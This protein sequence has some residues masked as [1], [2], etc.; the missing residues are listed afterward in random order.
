MYI[1]T[2]KV[3]KLITETLEDSSVK[4]EKKKK[5]T[6]GKYGKEGQRL[7]GYNGRVYHL[8]GRHQIDCNRAL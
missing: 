6:S 4:H 2:L 3:N 5:K 7:G 1:Y 8:M